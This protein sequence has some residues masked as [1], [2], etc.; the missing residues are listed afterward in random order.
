VVGIAIDALMVIVLSKTLAEREIG[1]WAAALIGLVASTA[2]T[3]LANKL[4][5]AIGVAGII[6][7]AVIAA[8]FLGMGLVWAYGVKI[9]RACLGGAIFSAVHLAY[10]TV[11]S[12]FWY[13]HL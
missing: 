5:T 8:L 11:V 12:W 7:A 6:V 10:V 1:F 13:G 2:T 3:I 9:K 4:M